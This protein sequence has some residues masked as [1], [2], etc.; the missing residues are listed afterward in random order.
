MFERTFV[1]QL[2]AFM[3]GEITNISDEDGQFADNRGVSLP[4]GI[5]D[6]DDL[7]GR[8]KNFQL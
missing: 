6:E 1:E 5:V 8:P 7:L 4:D 3:D 2:T